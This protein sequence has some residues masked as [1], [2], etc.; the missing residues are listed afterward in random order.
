MVAVHSSGYEC[1]AQ[2]LNDLCYDT[3]SVLKDK[4]NA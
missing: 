3:I 2:V 4:Q 1:T